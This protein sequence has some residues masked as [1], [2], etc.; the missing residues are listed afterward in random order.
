MATNLCPPLKRLF[1]EIKTGKP[2]A[3]TPQKLA[4]EFEQY[5]KDIEE[6]PIRIHTKY[7]RQNKKQQLM[8]NSEEKQQQDRVEELPCAPRVSDF[9]NRWL[10][11]TMGWWS[12]LSKPEQNQRHEEYH[13]IKQFI[14]GYCRNVKLNGAS[15]GVFNA[16]IIAR[17]LGL[18]DK[19]QV[20]QQSTQ[21]VIT[22][23]SAEEAQRMQELADM[24]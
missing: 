6:N 19:Q 14:N 15:A 20:E 18:A 17:E 3:Y 9:V 5:V 13:N 7:L 8:R 2:L 10:G 11:K 4:E 21:F 12:N 22:V 23:N 16:S 1:E 24:K